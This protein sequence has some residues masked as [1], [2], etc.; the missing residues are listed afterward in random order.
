MSNEQ[1]RKKALFQCCHNCWNGKMTERENKIIDGL[2]KLYPDAGCEL[3]H[4][5]VFEL[6]VA[7]ILSAQCTDER[8][9]K[10]TPA[11]FA[12][13][14][15]A[16]AMAAAP[17][18]DLETIIRP[19]GFFRSKALSIKE[20]SR[21]ITEDFGGEIPKDKEKLMTLRGVAGKTANVVLGSGYGIASGIVVDTHVKRLAFRLGLTQETD[22]VKI[23]AVLVKKIP[24]KDW[25]W[26]SH[27]LILHGRGPCNARKPDCAGC[28]LNL[29][30]PRKGIK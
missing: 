28:S 10:T 13:Y 5:N 23:E 16:A 22:P 12:K 3:N 9:N 21:K 25:I 19:T 8:V 30:C 2:K 29:L 14:P 18:E 17:V 24:Q 20:A 26:F 27:A 11:L 7:T 15:D 4:G 1:L 6:L